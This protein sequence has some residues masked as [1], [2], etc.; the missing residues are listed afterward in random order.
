ML[1][2]LFVK[3]FLVRFS[4][5]NTSQDHFIKRKKIF[6]TN[7]FRLGENTIFRSCFFMAKPRWQP[8]KNQTQ[9]YPVFECIGFSN[10]R[11]LVVHCFQLILFAWNL[12]HYFLLRL[13]LKR[14][15]ASTNVFQFRIKGNQAFYASYLLWQS[16]SNSF[17]IRMLPHKLDCI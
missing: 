16:F 5:V 6:Y 10:V 12:V 8:F 4:N 13:K 3:L 14:K 11:Y 15:F 17:N 2:L 7:H 1:I 9:I